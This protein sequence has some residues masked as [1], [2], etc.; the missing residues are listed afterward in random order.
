MAAATM[1]I[2]RWEKDRHNRSLLYTRDSRVSNHDLWGFFEKNEDR[3]IEAVERGNSL[4]NH[5]YGVMPGRLWSLLV[6]ALT[7]IDEEDAEYFLDC[8]R[9]DHPV[10]ED[11]PIRAAREMIRTELA[12]RTGNYKL[13]FIRLLK[14]W[15]AYRRGEP[16]SRLLFRM[17]GANPEAFPEPI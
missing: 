13:I 14:A 5:N 15:N 16:L 1:I 11:S 7:A 6:W 10:A 3:I 2:R 17:G 8:L 4:Y 9:Y 12:S